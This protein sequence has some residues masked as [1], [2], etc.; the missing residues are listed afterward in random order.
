CVRYPTTSSS[1]I[2]IDAEN[3]RASY[4]TGYVLNTINVG[5]TRNEGIEI[6]LDASIVNNSDFGWNMRFNVN[7]MWN[8]VVSLPSNVPEFYISDTWTFGNARGGLIT[9]GPTTAITAYGYQRNNAGQILIDPASGLPLVDQT[10]KVRGDRNPDLSV[11]WVNSFRYKNW[12]LSFLWDLKLGGD[13]FNATDMYLTARGV[14][15]RTDDRLTPRIISGVL[16][17]G[18]ENSSTPTA[19]TITIIPGYNDTY[20]GS[21]GGTTSLPEEEFIEKNINWFRLRDITLSYT[22]P[23]KLVGRWKFVKSLSIFATGNDLVL[24]SNYTGAD[25]SVSGNTAGTRGVGGWG[26]DYGNIAAPVSY[27]FGLRASF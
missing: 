2:S 17:D 27:N 23:A 3:F 15:A 4:G 18:K 24:F 1:C 22:L 13:V 5:T 16:K 20:Y 7:K 10:F 8:K 25:P 19:N 26:F 9:G 12:N 21:V 11:G 14:S 6:M